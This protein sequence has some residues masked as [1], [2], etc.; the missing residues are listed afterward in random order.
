MGLEEQGADQNAVLLLASSDYQN[1]QDYQLLART[2]H[3]NYQ[4]YQDYPTSVIPI[5][6]PV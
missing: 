4:D 2:M 3:Q 5:R 6:T 1:Y